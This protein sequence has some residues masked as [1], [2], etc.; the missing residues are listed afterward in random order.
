MGYDLR[1]KRVLQYLALTI[2]YSD[3]YEDI[4]NEAIIDNEDINNRK[5]KVFI[6]MSVHLNTITIPSDEELRNDLLEYFI[7]LHDEKEKR[8]VNR[9]RTH[10]EKRIQIL[11]KVNPIYFLDELT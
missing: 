11:K 9:E 7:L 4:C 6:S 5:I 8:K 1:T 10:I 3:L 2:I